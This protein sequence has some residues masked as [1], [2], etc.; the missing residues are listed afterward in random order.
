MSNTMLMMM[1]F[2][3]IG[4]EEEREQVADAI[5][6]IVPYGCRICPAEAIDIDRYDI[7]HLCIRHKVRCS[8]K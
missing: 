5:T 7:I 4:C 8:N 6:H 3:C 2:D 1:H